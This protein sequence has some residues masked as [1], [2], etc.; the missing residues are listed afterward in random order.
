VEAARVE[1]ETVEATTAAEREV[2]WREAEWRRT[3]VHETYTTCR[4]TSMGCN[5]CDYL[6]HAF[7]S[8]NANSSD[9]RKPPRR[10][11]CS[12]LSF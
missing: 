11:L 12:R 9:R 1:A 4:V 8:A 2:Q 10:F 3:C 7:S 6:R 5:D